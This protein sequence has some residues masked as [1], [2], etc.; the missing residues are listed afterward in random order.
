MFLFS[1]TFFP[2]SQYPDGLAWVVRLTRST[3]AWSSSEALVLGDPSPV[4][5]LTPRYLVAMGWLGLTAA[6]RRL[7]SDA[8]P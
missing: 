7:G 6:S 1:A 2:L 8:Q 5:L 3:R 4:P